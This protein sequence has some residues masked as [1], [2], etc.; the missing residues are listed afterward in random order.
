MRG[1]ALLIVQSFAT[2]EHILAS[3]LD[4]T[5][6]ECAIPYIIVDMFIITIILPINYMYHPF[7]LLSR[8]LLITYNLIASE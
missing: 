3:Y 5:F 4:C 1:R 7:A 6:I 2:V 8:K